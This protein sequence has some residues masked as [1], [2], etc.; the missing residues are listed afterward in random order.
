MLGWSH[1]MFQDDKAE[2]Q[3]HQRAE[4]ST[5]VDSADSDLHAS[6]CLVFI[7]QEKTE[8]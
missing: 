1:H 7:D 2:K 3:N 6:F 8:I 4:L 5:S